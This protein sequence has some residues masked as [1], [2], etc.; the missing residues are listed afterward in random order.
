MINTDT[1]PY[2]SRIHIFTSVSSAHNTHWSSSQALSIYRSLFSQSWPIL[3]SSELC[4]PTTICNL[5]SLFSAVG[6]DTLRRAASLNLMSCTRACAAT[7]L[8]TLDPATEATGF[9]L[10]L[11]FPEVEGSA[12]PRASSRVPFAAKKMEEVTNCWGLLKATPAARENL[13]YPYQL[14]A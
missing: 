1:M 14:P 7:S 5:A 8:V 9:K 13:A 2:Q 11:A 12:S 6:E 3:T 10:D 4:D